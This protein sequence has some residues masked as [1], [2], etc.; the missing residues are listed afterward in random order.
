MGIPITP[1]IDIWSLGCILSELDTRRVLFQ[2][3][4]ELDLLNIIR[5]KIGEIPETMIENCRRKKDYFDHRNKLVRSKRTPIN[6]FNLPTSQWDLKGE[7]IN[8]LDEDF[9]DFI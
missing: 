6:I 1:A 8:A 9:M 3:N 7:V 2:A 5:L 4:D